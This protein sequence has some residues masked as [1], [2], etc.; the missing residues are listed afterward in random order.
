MVNLTDRRNGFTRRASINSHDWYGA[1]VDLNK[2]LSDKL[3]DFG[4][5]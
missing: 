4:M 2:K 1:V 3:L 5:M